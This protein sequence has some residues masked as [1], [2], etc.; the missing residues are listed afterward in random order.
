MVAFALLLTVPA[1]MTGCSTATS[2]SNCNP[3]YENCDDNG[4]SGG[5]GG[6]V[7]SGGSASKKNSS[8]SDSG[9]YKGFGSGGKSSVGG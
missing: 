7:Y 9:I 2:R 8:S 1:V 4:Y 5:G 6:Y 3:N